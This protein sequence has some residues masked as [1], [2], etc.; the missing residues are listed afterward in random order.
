M[1]VP[2]TAILKPVLIRVIFSKTLH[3]YLFLVTSRMG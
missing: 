3:Q 1:A 2:K